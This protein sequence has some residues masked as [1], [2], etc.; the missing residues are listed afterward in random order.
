ME[1]DE[2]PEHSIDPRNVQ[3]ELVSYLTTAINYV[4]RQGLTTEDI[5]GTVERALANPPVKV[6][7]LPRPELLD[8]GV[9]DMRDRIN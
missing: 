1:V 5:E 3:R 4:R 7:V 6:R 9:N 8:K 2:I